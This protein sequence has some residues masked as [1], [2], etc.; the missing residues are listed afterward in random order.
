MLNVCEITCRLI[1]R[2]LLSCEGEG[3][4]ERESGGDAD[5]KPVSLPHLWGSHRAGDAAEGSAGLSQLGGTHSKAT[6]E[7]PQVVAW[8]PQGSELRRAE[9]SQAGP[10]CSVSENG[11]AESLQIPWSPAHKETAHMWP[12]IDLPLDLPRRVCQMPA[13]LEELQHPPK[14]KIYSQ[15]DR[16]VCPFPSLPPAL[17]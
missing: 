16:W 2:D 9:R 14:R 15:T 5:K 13:M 7:R 3:C 1:N 12:R 10:G 8:C 4:G 6:N 11:T 17:R